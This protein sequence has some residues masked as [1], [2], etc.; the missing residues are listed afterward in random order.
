[1]AST[2]TTSQIIITGQYA[3]PVSARSDVITPVN[4]FGARYGARGVQI[5]SPM[6][7]AGRPWNLPNEIKWL[8]LRDPQIFAGYMLWKTGV[9][10]D[11]IQVYASSNT[12]D[13][14]GKVS[15]EREKKAN[16]IAENV[17]WNL[18]NVKGGLYMKLLQILDMCIWGHK[19]GVKIYE[20]VTYGRWKGKVRLDRLRVMANDDYRVR[21]N[22]FGDLVGLQS[23]QDNDDQNIY[24]IDK[25]L[26][27]CFRPYDDH[28]LGTNIIWPCFNGWW[29]KQEM[30]PERLS[31]LAQF[32]SPSMWANAPAGI[33]DVELVGVDGQ[34]MKYPATLP[35]GSPHPQ[36]GNAVKIPVNRHLL[37]SLEN[38]Q[39]NGSVIV[40]P[41]DTKLNLLQAQGDGSQFK[42]FLDDKN[43]EFI[44][45]IFFT[46]GWTENEKYASGAKGKQSSAISQ[47]S[48]MD[49]K[50]VL[51]DILEASIARDL[52]IYNFGEDYLDLIPEITLGNLESGALASIFNS[53][54]ALWSTGFFDDSQRAELCKRMSLPMPDPNQKPQ[55]QRVPTGNVLVN[56]ADKTPVGGNDQPKQEEDDEDEE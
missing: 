8:M 27:G 42:S 54:A 9:L 30:V 39:G 34:P 51:S 11:G 26:Y 52:V 53:V 13:S 47:C 23:I 55:G 15:K 33:T 37:S 48:L 29:E 18:N 21:T 6:D 38:F 28:V 45:A 44:K 35:D 10:V 2:S 36:A 49:G 41:T 7:L 14:N 17:L 43:L 40:V 25:F 3:K 22:E 50:K 24:G 5:P 31:N 56:N 32:G 16:E 46:T 1:M 4:Q 19:A 20:E 12:K